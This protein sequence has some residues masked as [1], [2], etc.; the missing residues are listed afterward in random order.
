MGSIEKQEVS[1]LDALYDNTT[2]FLKTTHT[3]THT[4]H[5]R[6]YWRTKRLFGLEKFIDQL[7]QLQLSSI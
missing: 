5:Y 3:H 2:C 4:Q 7:M 6:F 1:S